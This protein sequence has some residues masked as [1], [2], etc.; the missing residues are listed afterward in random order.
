LAIIWFFAYGP[1]RR[2]FGAQIP[3]WAY[4]RSNISFNLP[5]ILPWF[6][7]S[8]CTDLIALLP[9][10]KPK[11]WLTSP[12]GQ[13]LYFSCFLALLVVVAPSLIKSFWLCRSLAQGPKRQRIEAMC[14]RAGMGYR[15]ILDWPIFEGRLLSAAVMG[16]VKR[17]RYILVTS[18]LLALL[19]DEEIDAVVAHEI[20]HIKRRHLLFYLIFFIGFL[21]L[22]YSVYDLVLYGI[23]YGN[24][25]FPITQGGTEKLTAWT[26]ILFAAAMA[27][28]L[29]IYFRFVFGFFMRNCE[30]QADLYAFELLG[31]SRGLVSSLEKIA[32]YSGNSHDRPSWHHFSIRQRI[33]YLKKCES[34][35]RW[36][37]KHDGKLRRSIAAFIVALI[38]VGYFGATIDFG[39]MSETLNSRFLEKVIIKEIETNPTNPAL[40]YMLGTIHYQNKSFAQAIDAYE[41]AVSLGPRHAE[42][43]NNLAWIY[44][45]CEEAGLRSPVKALAY[46]LTA[47]AVNPKAHILDTLAESYY[48]NGRYEEAVSA[49]KAALSLNPEDRDY[50]EKQLS[51]FKSAM[52]EG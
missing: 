46:A 23:F 12:Q 3:R 24:L 36:I 47:A 37:E 52:K 29:L 32:V 9:F 31:D 16:L 1:Y 45:T 34:D 30:R 25:A 15:D 7:I 11:L 8:L 49:I 6:L 44:A 2:L 20:G 19:N 22:I 48:I 35:R 51:K 38:T 18:S 17:F 28:I 27:V 5:I 21:V 39:E 13:V 26:S 42:A 50:Y 10:E 33:D 40:F 41:K 14:H 43:L 4:V